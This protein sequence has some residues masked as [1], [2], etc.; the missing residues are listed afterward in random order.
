VKP[1]VALTQLRL[2]EVEKV[3]AQAMAL[4]QQKQ[5]RGPQ[6]HRGESIVGPQG[7]SG[8][9]GKDSTVA[10]PPGRD[11][12]NGRNGRDGKDSTVA[13]PPGRDGKNGRDGKDADTQQLNSAV[14]TVK[15]VREEIMGAIKSSNQQRIEAT[16]QCQNDIKDQ[17]RV[18]ADIRA[19]LSEMRLYVKT[20]IDAAQKS[21]DYLDFLRE[22]TAK[23]LA[24]S[25]A[26]QRAK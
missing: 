7:P 1:V 22:R 2:A 15:N 3:A 6:G 25:A 8:K 13:G 20:I 18:I 16:V 24:K 5:E 11:A 4:A 14:E 26:E 19:E 12:E 21:K 9:D 10:G 17:N 23:I